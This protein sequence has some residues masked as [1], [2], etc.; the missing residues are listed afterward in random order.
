MPSVPATPAAP[1]PAFTAADLQ[2]LDRILTEAAVEEILPRFNRLGANA[3]RTKSS[4]IDL[5]TD[6]DEAAEATI[7]AALTR[8][9]PTARVIGEEA[10]AADPT[11]LDALGEASLA[12]V[13]D[14]I[15]GTRNFAAGLP[16]FGVMAAAVAGGQVVGAVIH[17]PLGRNSA[18]ALRDGGAWLQDTQGE[19]R[20]LHVSRPVTEAARMDGY[21][22]LTHLP[23]PLRQT[24]AGNLARLR[25]PANLRCAAHEYRMAASGH[26][27]ILLYHM[28]MPWDHA[29]GWLL[30]HEA[31]GYSAH[32]DGSPYRP[33]RR[34]G[35]LLCAPDEAS[36]QLAYQALI[37]S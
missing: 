26:C 30:H 3:V 2:T 17:D 36:W 9:F 13:V 4:A 11:L 37:G 28:L 22:G 12:F 32:F 21:I 35:G 34:D 25:S 19:K 24:V 16:L 18:M 7:T 10:C 27:D 23:P 29:P 31:G 20:R 1:S 6:A 5:V 14:P 15:D 8:V 33:V